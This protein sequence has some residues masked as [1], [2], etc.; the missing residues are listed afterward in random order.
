[1]FEDNDFISALQWQGTDDI[2]AYLSVP[3]AIEFQRSHDWRTVRERCHAMLAETLAQLEA[4]TGVPS[5]YPRQAPRLF[6][7]MGVAPLPLQ[8]DIAAFKERLYSE[9]RIEVP[10]YVWQGGHYMRISVQAYNTPEELSRLVEATSMLL[11]PTPMTT[12]F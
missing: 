6:H 5:C 4:V 1:M 9:H 3:A 10:C 11:Q 8:P 7:Q 12:A 2:S